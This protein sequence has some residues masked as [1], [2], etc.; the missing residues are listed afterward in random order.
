MN[1]LDTMGLGAVYLRVWR[2]RSPARKDIL[3]GTEKDEQQI[4]P[5]RVLP[6]RSSLALHGDVWRPLYSTRFHTTMM[7]YKN[8]PFSGRKSTMN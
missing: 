7:I 5:A 6:D 4:Q 8:F 2:A 1:L 3:N